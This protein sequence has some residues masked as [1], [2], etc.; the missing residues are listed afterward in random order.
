MPKRPIL[1]A[2]LCLA[3]AAAS[4][5]DLSDLRWLLGDWRT[6]PLAEGSRYALESWREVSLLTF[7]GV[8]ETRCAATDTL[9][10][11]ETIRL[12]EMSGEAFYIAKTP[13]NELPVSFALTDLGPSRVEFTNPRHDFPNLIRYRA[14]GEDSLSVD[15]MDMEDDGFTIGFSKVR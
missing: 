1:I 15:V 11:L 8:S 9:L 5:A 12:V 14:V 10:S 4:A 7:E 13:D 3:A 2:A 6:E